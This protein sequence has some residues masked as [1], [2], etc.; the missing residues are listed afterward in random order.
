MRRKMGTDFREVARYAL[1][2]IMAAVLLGFIFRFALQ[3]AYG[4]T[5]EEWTRSQSWSILWQGEGNFQW[6]Q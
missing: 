4:A 2:I 3:V 5:P 1:V 6:T